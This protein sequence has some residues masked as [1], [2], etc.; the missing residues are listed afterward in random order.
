MNKFEEELINTIVE[1]GYNSRGSNNRLLS[2]EASKYFFLKNCRDKEC[3]SYI[4]SEQY[5]EPDNLEEVTNEIFSRD[6]VYVALTPCEDYFDK[7]GNHVR[8]IATFT[9]RSLDKN[10]IIK[11]IDWYLNEGAVVYVYL[12]YGLKLGIGGVVESNPIK[13]TYWWRMACTKGD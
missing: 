1:F 9:G 6:K 7:E 10:D 11:K 8:E 12:F 13:E 3:L 2:K 5:F 4:D